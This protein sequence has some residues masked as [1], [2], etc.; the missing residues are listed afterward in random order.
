MFLLLSICNFLNFANELRLDR[1]LPVEEEK[2][3]QEKIL[4]KVY[5]TLPN[6][7]PF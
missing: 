2:L 7:M 4:N 1:T 6:F 3:R 5:H